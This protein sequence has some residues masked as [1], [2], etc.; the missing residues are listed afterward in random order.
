M[1]SH[2]RSSI[3]GP[4]EDE[5]H[6]LKNLD[7]SFA[8]RMNIITEGALCVMTGKGDASRPPKEPCQKGQPPRACVCRESHQLLRTKG[9]SG[10]GRCSG[11]G[12]STPCDLVYTHKE[13]LKLGM[14]LSL[15][16]SYQRKRRAVNPQEG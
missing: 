2:T 11:Q 1:G 4:W 9:V 14:P 5:E 3:T 12:C 6:D 8:R 7:R 13:G 15:F 16:P 10:S